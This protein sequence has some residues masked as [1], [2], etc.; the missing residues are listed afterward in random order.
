MSNAENSFQSIFADLLP[1]LV[2]EESSIVVLYG[3]SKEPMHRLKAGFISRDE[4]EA[5]ANK[6]VDCDGFTRYIV[7][8]QKEKGEK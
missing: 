8:D 7:I 2:Y 3:I 5:W 6:Q 1:F 4:A